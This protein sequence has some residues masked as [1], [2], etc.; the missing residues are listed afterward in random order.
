MSFLPLNGPRS[1]SRGHSIELVEGAR[2]FKDRPYPTSP[3]K[4]KVVEDEMGKMLALGVIEESKSPWSNRTTVVSKP[5]KDR[6]CLDARKLNALTVKDAYF[7]H[8][9]DCIPSIIDQ[10]HYTYLQSG[11]QV[12]VLADRIGLDWTRRLRFLTFGLCNAA[13]R[14]V[15]LMNRCDSYKV[16]IGA[17]LFLRKHDGEEQVIEFFSAKMNKHQ[18]NYYADT[19]SQ[20]VSE[21]QEWSRTDIYRVFSHHMFLNGASYKLARQLRSTCDHK[22]EGMQAKNKFRVIHAKVQKHLEGGYDKPAR[23]LHAKPGQD[24]FR[25]SFV[26]CDFSKAFNAKLAPNFLK[27]RVPNSSV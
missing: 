22:M 4:Q 17:V 25:R 19:L 26:L 3:A 23:T 2:P 1:V 12:C 15:R 5:G 10:T 14:L 24:V 16:A 7:L 27:A 11:S 18:V 8:S 9:V 21:V 6:F 20:Q 13:Q